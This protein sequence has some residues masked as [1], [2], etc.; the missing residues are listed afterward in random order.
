M[1]KRIGMLLI[2]AVTCAAAVVS[3]QYFHVIARAGLAFSAPPTDLKIPAAAQ[4]AEENAKTLSVEPSAQQSDVNQ[5]QSASGV[6]G[7]CS[8]LARRFESYRLSCNLGS[9]DR[10]DAL[11]RGVHGEVSIQKLMHEISG[12]TCFSPVGKKA[13]RHLQGV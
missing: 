5:N 11:C 6:V 12:V 7:K 3:A 2:I 8:D 4:A 10:G 9:F 13:V 1:T